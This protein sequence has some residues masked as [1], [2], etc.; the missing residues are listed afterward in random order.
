MRGERSDARRNRERLIREARAMFAEGAAELRLDELARRAGVGIGT[1]YRHFP[2][3]SALI[4]AVYREEIASLGLA[5]RDLSAA[6]APLAALRAWMLLF[7][8]YI[9]AKRL[10]AP[11]LDTAGGG[12]ST[13]LAEGN[14]AVI[15]A[16]DMLVARAVAA[17]ELRDTVEPLDLLRAIAGL[18]YLSNNPGWT[19]SARRLIDILLA[20]SR[21]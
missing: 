2:D 12:R 7:I 10:I 4:E 14:V 19:D 1:L 15:E 3:R 11:A 16:I 6:E 9:A 13:V 8:D 20:G 5:A 18:A 21:P 17:G